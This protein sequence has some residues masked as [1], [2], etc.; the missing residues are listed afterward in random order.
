MIKYTTI[1]P[2]TIYLIYIVV[3]YGVQKSI[4]ISWYKLPKK[5]KW[6]FLVAL[7]GTSLLMVSTYIYSQDSIKLDSLLLFFA[8]LGICYTA[9]AAAFKKDKVTETWHMAGAYGGFAFGYA[10]IVARLG[11]DSLMFI[12]LSM[13]LFVISYFVEREKRTIHETS[14]YTYRYNHKLIWWAEIIGL[15]TIYLATL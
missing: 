7:I 14:N 11:G 5:R 9:S 8:G 6:M 3:K 10:F 4:S 12:Y 13:F 15:L 1:L 2:I